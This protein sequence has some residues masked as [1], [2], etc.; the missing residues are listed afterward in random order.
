MVSELKDYLLMRVDRYISAP[1]GVKEW[2]LRV[3]A[4]VSPLYYVKVIELG[5]FF[6][7][8]IKSG[9]LTKLHHCLVLAMQRSA[10]AVLA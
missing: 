4:S 6:T 9:C 7:Y 3:G 8:Q 5:W 1:G 2:I 10:S